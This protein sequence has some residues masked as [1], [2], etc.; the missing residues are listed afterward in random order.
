LQATGSGQQVLSTSFVLPSGSLQAIRGNWRYL[1]SA[2]S[3]CSGG[4]YDDRDDLVFAVQN[5]VPTVSI[6]SPANGAL[7]RGSV[8]V[9]V[10]ATD[11]LGVSRVDLLVDG[12]VNGSTS[13]A[14]YVIALNTVGF[15]DGSHQIQAKATDTAGNTGLSAIVTIRV[16]NTPPI[17]SITS[18]ASGATVSGTVNVTASATDATSGVASVDFLLDGAV[19]TTVTVSPYTW[20]WNTTTATAGSHVLAARAHDNAGNIA[21]SANVSVTVSN[22]VPET[23]AAFCAALGD[24][25]GTVSGTDNCGNARTV[26]SCGTCTA[27]NTCGGGGK[28]NVCGTMAPACFPIYSINN[29]PSYTAG[30]RVSTG[31]HNWLCSNGNCAN[32]SWQPG[33][34]PGA[35][36]CPWGVVWTDQGPCQ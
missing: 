15:S 24:N 5:I 6:T 35:S 34:A 16:D 2:A 13:T 4:A 33:C 21:T 29:C 17:V 14:P 9:D 18:P 8:A 36:G 28:P 3:T 11:S 7:A 22:C 10:S 1:G 27:P 31:G 19:Q 30:T 23:D 25:C 26:A 32:C 12:A 20:S